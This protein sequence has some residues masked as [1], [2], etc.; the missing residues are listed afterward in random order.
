MYVLMFYVTTFSIDSIS[1]LDFSIV[2]IG[3]IAASFS[4]ALTN[5]GLGAYPLAV[6]ISFSVFGVNEASGLAFG[7]IMWASQTVMIIFFGGISLIFLP[8]YNR[9]HSKKLN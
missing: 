6:A 9:I 4:V 2:L 5:G 8:I 1:G 3:F 7:L